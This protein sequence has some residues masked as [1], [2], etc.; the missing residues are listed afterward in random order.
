MVSWSRTVVDKK[1]CEE[2]REKIVSPNNRFNQSIKLNIFLE[3]YLFWHNK[4]S[5]TTPP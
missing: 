2:I 4:R 5:F 3:L 1:Y